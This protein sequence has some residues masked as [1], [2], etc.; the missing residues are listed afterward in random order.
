[1]ISRLDHNPS[2]FERMRR[3]WQKVAR[4]KIPE[5]LGVNT[6]VGAAISAAS[7][8]E[9]SDGHAI[10]RQ[11]L[12]KGKL[13][14][15]RGYGS[16][17]TAGDGLRLRLYANDT[18]LLDSDVVSLAAGSNKPWVIKAQ[19]HVLSVAT[20]TAPGQV[21]AFLERASFDGTAISKA[22]AVVN[23]DTAAQLQFQLRA[24][25]S[26]GGAGNSITE[27]IFAITDA[28]A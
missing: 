18:L 22:G 14:Q 10:P 21:T 24:A 26:T 19:V 2:D 8:T 15:I 12:T 27:Q 11:A 16:Y 4:A 1:M 5:A 23:L 6:A 28:G 3:E 13:L 9:L 7:E 25:W 17:T 20:A